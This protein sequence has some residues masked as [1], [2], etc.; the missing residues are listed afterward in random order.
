MT[1]SDCGLRVVRTTTEHAEHLL[2]TDRPH[3]VLAWTV[4]AEGP[5]N[6]KP[7]GYRVCVATSEMALLDGGD[8]VWDSGP[9]RSARTSVAYPGPPLRPRTRYAWRVQ[10]N[11]ADGCSAPWSRPTWFETGLLGEDW[12]ASWIGGAAPAPVRPSLDGASWIGAP[13][14]SGAA[15]FHGAVLIPP[16]AAP[17]MPERPDLRSARNPGVLTVDATGACVVY[18]NGRP[19]LSTGAAAA[20]VRRAEVVPVAGLAGAV[21]LS[22]EV[23]TV[24]GVRPELIARLDAGGASLVTDA[25]WEADRRPVEVLRRYGVLPHG[26]TT[27]VPVEEE[28]A[29]LLRRAFRIDRPV[30][31]ARLYASGLG[32]HRLW[33]NGSPVGDAVLEP[34]FTD[35]DHTVL[36]V[37][38]DVTALVG[39]GDNAIGAELGRGFYA[40][41]TPNMWDWHRPPW[42]DE[43][44]LLL[45]LVVEHDDGTTTEIGT[46]ARWRG[47]GGPTAANSLYAGESYDARREI[48]GWASAGFDDS[49]WD[50]V[51]LREAPKGVLRAQ[52]HEPIRVVEDLPARTVREVGPGV[53]VADFGRTV[54]GWASITTTAPAGTTLSLR[55]GEL[56]SP[57]GKAVE[58]ANDFVD[59]VRFQLDEYTTAG[60]DRETWEPQ[61]SYKGFR[62]VQIE[63]G[64]DVLPHTTVTARVAHSDVPGTARFAC[65]VELYERYELAMRRTIANNMHGLLTDTPMYEKNGWTGD[66]QV[67]APVLGTAFDLRRLL[68]KWLGDMRDSQRPD[69]QLPVIVPSAGWGFTELAPSPEWTTLYPY[70]LREMHRWYGDDRLLEEHYQPVSRYLE[71]EL[72]RLAGGLALTELG[73]WLAP[74]YPGIPPEDARLTATAYLYRGLLSMAE[75]AE[76]LNRDGDAARMRVAAGN[77]KDALNSTFLDRAGGRYA[78]AKDPEY[79]QA[80][81]AVP[82]A[83]G[84]VPEDCVR[85]VVDGLVDDLRSRDWHLNTGCLGTSVLLPV[86]TRYGHAECAARLATQTTYPS[87]GHWF[88]GDGDTMW[89]A[90]SADYRSRDH[91]FLGTVVQWL[92]ENVAGLRAGHNGW[93]RFIVRP[94]ARVGVNSASLSLDTVRGEAAVSWTSSDA[95]RM[96]VEVP[97]GSTAEVHVPG[98]ELASV[99]V[100]GA[101][102]AEPRQDGEYVVC[103]VGSGTWQFI[104]AVGR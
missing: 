46:D 65:D 35:Y 57:D 38:H 17:S 8:L 6:N 87:W 19:V 62:Y 67:A 15:V 10:V 83:F 20:L 41:T 1:G 5:K 33:L 72:G 61:F 27:S 39:P 75:V 96:T 9:V 68:T 69:G 84:L 37:V 89:E 18:L 45:R 2:G 95:F 31:A 40:M 53:R 3:P 30:R 58:A 98:P 99:T 55:Y 36:Y 16:D 104:S 29:P 70:L 59:P 60:R 93:E 54:A 32:Y 28:P 14:G 23:T 44:K 21:E 64:P 79:R 25:S 24:D 90:W 102:L 22:V 100:D 81:N 91:Y 101:P 85:S 76:L 97:F 92:Y 51:A 47:A 12:H 7:T 78:T 13:A 73:D 26:M 56:L 94:D 50:A 77:L 66:A 4:T 49:A 88:D 11:D 43:P 82:L 63:G 86:L 103:R 42:H 71:W 52:S 48:E 74:G 80:S 34:G